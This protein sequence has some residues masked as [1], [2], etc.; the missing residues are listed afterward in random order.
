MVGKRLEEGDDEGCGHRVKHSNRSCG[1]GE[2]RHFMFGDP[3]VANVDSL[4]WATWYNDL[5]G[6]CRPN[7]VDETRER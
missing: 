6:L 3:L 7:E 4:N 1:L 5:G 2:A